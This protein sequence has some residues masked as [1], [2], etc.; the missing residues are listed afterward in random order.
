[1]GFRIPSITLAPELKGPRSWFLIR[2]KI[3][4]FLDDERSDVG[5]TA[6]VQVSNGRVYLRY[7]VHDYRV[8]MAEDEDMLNVGDTIE[9]YTNWAEQKSYG[10][11]DVTRDHR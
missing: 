5:D 8:V 4:G 9:F 2:G 6:V 7:L 3:I 11:Y 1:M 10:V